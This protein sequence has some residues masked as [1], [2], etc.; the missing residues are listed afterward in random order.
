MNTAL[1]IKTAALAAL[2]LLAPAAPAAAMPIYGNNDYLPVSGYAARSTLA[3]LADST[4]SFFRARD[5][6]PGGEVVA[7]TLGK[8]YD[9]CKDDPFFSS[10]TVGFCSGVL[11]EPDVV[12]T[13]AHCLKDGCDGVKIVFGY[14]SKEPRFVL[15]PENV[16][17]CKAVLAGPREI[18]D[19]DIALVKLDRK[20]AGRTPIGISDA[21]IEPGMRLASIGHPKGMPQQ[22]QP[23]VRVLLVAE[24]YDFFVTDM[25]SL[26]GQS[27]SPVFDQSGRVLGVHF[28]AIGA[29]S[30]DNLVTDIKGQCFRFGALKENEWVDRSRLPED[31]KYDAMAVSDTAG[32]R[33]VPVAS[34]AVAVAP[35]LK[36]H[37]APKAGAVSLPKLPSVGV[38]A[39]GRF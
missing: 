7:N 4:V 31:P 39:R 26:G 29:L 1:S 36:K 33:S 12:L 27:G 6:G 34:S 30:G 5:I 14:V 35:A 37:L 23:D 25:D 13:A 28:S 24:G 20:A 15:P 21:K 17:G 2:C 19:G 38:K 32:N 18:P 9:L 8:A 11:V 16:Y 3:K 10:P 22:I